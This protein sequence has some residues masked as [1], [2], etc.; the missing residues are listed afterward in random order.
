MV[1]FSLLRVEAESY[2]FRFNSMPTK[3]FIMVTFIGLFDYQLSVFSL[4]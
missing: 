1:V 3:Y 2:F 4:H